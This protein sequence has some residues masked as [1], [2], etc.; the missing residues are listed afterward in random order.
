MK[1]AMILRNL[2]KEITKGQ[3]KVKTLSR[4]NQ[5]VFRLDILYPMCRKRNIIK[6]IVELESQLKD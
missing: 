1:Y 4:H 6:E 2:D 5:H 3:D